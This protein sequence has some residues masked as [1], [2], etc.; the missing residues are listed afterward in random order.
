MNAAKTHLI[1]ERETLK[2]EDMK[3]IIA[4][5]SH[6]DAI[7]TLLSLSSVRPLEAI[8][9]AEILYHAQQLHESKTKHAELQEKIK[10]I[11]EELE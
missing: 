9:T 5:K 11:T 8:D 10:R 4:A 3:A 7:K 6:A 2:Q 1:G